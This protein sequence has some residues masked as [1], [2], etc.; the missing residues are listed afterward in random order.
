MKLTT[1]FMNRLIEWQEDGDR[2]VQVDI[3]NKCRML[4]KD[5][6]RVWVYDY[7]FTSGLYITK[8]SELP[9][10]AD[11]REI[12]AARIEDERAGLEKRLAELEGMEG[13]DGRA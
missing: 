10:E 2:S 13:Q 7:T 5:G 6:I 4:G 1:E 9:T 12:T 8:L 11:L 3:E